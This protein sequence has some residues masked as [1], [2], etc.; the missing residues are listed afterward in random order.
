MTSLF[1]A[2]VAAADPVKVIA[3]NLP[4]RPKGHTIV[5][6]AGKGSAQMAK[7]L[8]SHWDGPLAG[9]VVS[10]YGFGVACERIEIIEASHPVP[11]EAGLL[12][13]RRLLEAVSSLSEDDLVISLISGGGSALL[14]APAD[15]VTRLRTRSPSTRLFSLPAP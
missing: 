8:E 12:A 9:V 6:G 3:A 10:R 14:P 4:P 11:D 1:N 15:G 2:V 5:I 7:A 13:S